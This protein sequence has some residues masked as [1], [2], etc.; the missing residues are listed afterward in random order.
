MFFPKIY[1]IWPY[2]N[3]TIICLL[4]RLWFWFIELTNLLKSLCFLSCIVILKHICQLAIHQ[5][6]NYPWH[7]IVLLLGNISHPLLHLSEAV[8]L[9]LVNAV[10][11]EVVSMTSGTS[12]IR[13]RYTFS[14]IFYLL[15][16][17]E[18]EISEVPTELLLMV[19][20]P[21]GRSLALWPIT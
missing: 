2:S 7:S 14:M 17:A 11:T 16:L 10:S 4:E 21:R 3:L 1:I 20:S 5:H 9:L 15:S 18:S 8:W 6:L 12:G 13:R 19:E